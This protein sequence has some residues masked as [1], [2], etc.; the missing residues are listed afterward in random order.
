MRKKRIKRPKRNTLVYTSILGKIKI[1]HCKKGF[2]FEVRI[3]AAP[4]EPIFG[5]GSLADA[6]KHLEGTEEALWPDH[7]QLKLWET[8]RIKFTKKRAKRLILQIYTDNF[9]ATKMLK[10]HGLI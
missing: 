1:W 4:N 3:E 6:M 5:C 2:P 9:E 10:Y 7:H 8:G